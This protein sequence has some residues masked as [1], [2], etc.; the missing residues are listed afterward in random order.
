MQRRVKGLAAGVNFFEAGFRENAFE[1]LLNHGDAGLQG[2]RPAWRGWCVLRGGLRHFKMVE[3]GQQFVE[4][5]GGGRL[6]G[7]VAF[8][9]GA[10]LEIFKIGGGAQQA[11]P[12]L[13]G[14]G[15][16]GLEFGQL[17]RGG[18]RRGGEPPAARGAQ[19]GTA[20]AFWCV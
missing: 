6:R 16:A 4:Q 10:F 13:V 14:L 9:G 18:F 8:A 3:H 5:R 2:C 7:V 15:G 19:A 17:F 20:S 1:L 11:V 12:M